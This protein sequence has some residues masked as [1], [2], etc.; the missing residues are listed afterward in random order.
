MVSYVYP[1]FKAPFGS[2]GGIVVDDGSHNTTP[3]GS[4]HKGEGGRKEKVEWILLLLKDEK[5]VAL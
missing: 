3:F 4:M 1:Q 5:K 2:R